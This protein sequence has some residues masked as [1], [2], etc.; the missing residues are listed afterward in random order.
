MFWL[1]SA[2]AESNQRRAK[3]DALGRLRALR[4]SSTIACPFGI[5]VLRGLLRQMRSYLSGARSWV[6]LLLLP[7]SSH[8]AF[9]RRT[10]IG[11]STDGA[12]GAVRNAPRPCEA[13]GAVGK[14]AALLQGVQEAIA[15]PT[16]S[17]Y[18][19]K[20]PDIEGRTNRRISGFSFYTVL[21]A[22]SF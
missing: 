4:L 16:Q 1:L 11:T 7:G 10:V 22:C 5:P 15:G 21:G 12:P 3:G 13:A 20:T 19:A 14:Q 8:F 6:W 18:R 9:A 2:R 17:Q